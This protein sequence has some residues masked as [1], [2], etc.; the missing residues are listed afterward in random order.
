MELTDK[1][2]L[3]LKK[4]LDARSI[5]TR[6]IKNTQISYIGGDTI[7]STANA[8]FGY[9]GWK[10][11]IVEKNI[12][13][14]TSHVVFKDIW[15][16][17]RKTGTKEEKLQYISFVEVV[18]RLSINDNLIEDIGTGEGVAYTPTGHLEMAIKGAVTDAKKRCFRNYGDQFGNIL[19]GDDKSNI[20]NYDPKQ[21]EQEKQK[22]FKKIE[23]EADKLQDL[24][25]KKV[26]DLLKKLDLN[27]S[28]II[29]PMINAQYI[30]NIVTDIEDLSNKEGLILIKFLSQKL[31]A[32]KEELKN[33]NK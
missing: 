24:T 33:A 12:I 14:N 31:K 21:I 28:D 7:I 23:R 17:G 6:K 4:P 19:Y 25:R 5:K 26:N 11:E 9:N 20:A 15:E 2:L 16:N 32:K 18:G 8:I 29:D 22:E 30:A 13:V 1:Q 10:F 3:A 27:F